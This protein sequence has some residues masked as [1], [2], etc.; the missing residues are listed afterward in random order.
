MK[1]LS[2]MSWSDS[3]MAGDDCGYQDDGNARHRDGCFQVPA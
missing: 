3:N 1:K 2:L